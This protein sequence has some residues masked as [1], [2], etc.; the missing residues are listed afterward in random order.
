MRRA[1]E[2]DQLFSALIFWGPPGTGKMTL[3]MIVANTT[4]IHFET[5]SAVLAGV[6]DL[7]RVIM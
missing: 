2:A 6:V 1:I 5:I 7:R 3:A 4:A